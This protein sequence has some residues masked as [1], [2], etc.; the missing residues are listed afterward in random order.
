MTARAKR[1]AIALSLLAVTVVAIA[2]V[3][4]IRTLGTPTRS[5]SDVVFVA[6]PEGWRF[7]R[8]GATGVWLRPSSS[9][10]GERFDV[11]RAVEPATAL[12]AERGILVRARSER[13]KVV[14]IVNTRTRTV[15]ARFSWATTGVA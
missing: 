10:E 14:A 4:S 11:R 15:V 1:V 5:S 2:L 7:L 8:A 6:R 13:G 3:A 9:A 12:S